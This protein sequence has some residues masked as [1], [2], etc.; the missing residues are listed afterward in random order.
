MD[1]IIYLIILFINV[2]LS[3][4]ENSSKFISKPLDVRQWSEKLKQFS[5]DYFY[6][7]IHVLT[8]QIY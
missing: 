1:L 7:V 2:V 6:E 5:K 4:Y 8:I 3:K